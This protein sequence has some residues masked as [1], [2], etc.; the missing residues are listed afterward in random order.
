MM[1]ILFS[2]YAL[3]FFHLPQSGSTKNLQQKTG[4]IDLIQF[5]ESIS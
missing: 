3:P 1:K 2:D 4:M 5:N